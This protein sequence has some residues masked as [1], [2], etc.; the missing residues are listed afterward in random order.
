MINK[1]LSAFISMSWLTVLVAC[2]QTEPVTPASTETSNDSHEQNSAL[3]A[4]YDLGETTLLQDQ[5]PE[6][7]Q[8][9][10]MPV[11]LS[12]VIGIPGGEGAHP[13]VLILHG[14]HQT[15]SNGDIWPCAPEEEQPNY[16]GFKYLVEALA[17]DGYVALSIDI[18]A[19]YTFA[20][21]EAPPTVRTAQLIDAHMKELAAAN[22]GDS[23]KFGL[24]LRGRIDLSR[25]VWLGHSRGGDYAN[26]IVRQQN[27]DEQASPVGYGPVQGLILMAPPVFSPEV[28]PAVDLPL[29]VILPACDSDVILLDGQRYYESA[30]FDPARTQLVTS[31]YLEGGNHEGFNTVLSAGNILADRSDCAA[32][33]ALSSEAQQEFMVRYTLEFLNWLYSEPYQGEAAQV[34]GLDADT[35]SPMQ[36]FG[37]PVQVN[38]AWPP[39][40]RTSIIVPE[41]EAELDTNLLGGEVQTSGV[42]VVFCPEGYYTPEMEPGSE[43]CQRVYFNQPGYPQQFVLRWETPRAEWRTLIPESAGDLS[44]YA[45]LSLRVALNPLSDL[46]PQ[47]ADQSFSVVLRDA[48]GAQATV[49]VAG[50]PYPAGIRQ[51][52]E[53]FEG[54]SFTGHVHMKTLRLPLSEF[55]G[56]DLSKIITIALA[57][58]QRDSGE[59]FIADLALI[60]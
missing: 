56:V 9:R 10:N 58:D 54:D 4:V 31:V 20:F 14:S 12:G 29:A 1:G 40:G 47:G 30:R 60:Q 38:T 24:D 45:N 55:S 50:L 41:S 25:M 52:S 7:S 48:N 6:D 37:L 22:L 53:F 51:P 35:T 2:T 11:R 18:N 13:V 15:C 57:F 49:I 27:L 44:S 17:N 42:S 34:L 3:V 39:A 59:L 26:W 46:N 33:S 28:L 23:D 21:G 43:A 8:F 16:D 19:E 36:L 32:G 5:F